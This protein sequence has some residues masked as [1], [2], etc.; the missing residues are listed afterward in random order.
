[1]NPNWYIHT[2]S[3]RPAVTAGSFCRTDPAAALRALANSRSPASAWRAF[4]SA[5]APSGM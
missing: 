4:R 1:M 3:P 5:N 2:A